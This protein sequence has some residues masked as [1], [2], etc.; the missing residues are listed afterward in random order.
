MVVDDRT[1]ASLVATSLISLA[2]FASPS[3]AL[4]G[5]TSSAPPVT[6]PADASVPAPPAMITLVGSDGESTF[7]SSAHTVSDVL[8]ERGIAI[9]AGDYVSPSPASPVADGTR[10]VVRQAVSVRI[11]SGR[12]ARTVRTSAAS[13]AD[14]LRDERVAV[15]HGQSVEPSVTSQPSPGET[16][17]IVAVASWTSH[18]RSPIAPKIVHRT[19]ASLPLGEATVTSGR[20][21]VR[22]TV[23]R[24]TRRDGGRPERT[25]LA[26]RIIREP[27]PKV[28]VRGLATYSSLARVASQGF[29]SA[30]RMAGSALHMI[31]TAY[32][33]GCYGCSGMT[34]SGVRAG[35]GVIAVDPSIV[36]LGTKVFIPGYGRAVAGDTG[37]AIL[38]HRVDLGFNTQT[39]A[40]HFGR[41][42]IT[43]YVLR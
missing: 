34:A 15:R 17:R 37:G 23:L 16:I 29:E 5:E 38:G 14:L 30:V 24:M 43:L 42:P 1:V 41:R 35:F 20:P 25:V 12:R 32:S 19:D 28:I 21:G 36:P 7:P 9:E 4:A 10:I 3:L 6:T 18:V 22:E 2:F 27:S 39:A 40:M 26:S 31:A 8:A 33:A 13:V 11:V